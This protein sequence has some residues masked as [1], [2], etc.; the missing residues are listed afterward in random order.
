[1]IGRTATVVQACR[2]DGTVRV[3]G[4]IWEAHCSEGADPDETVRITSLDG[5]RLTVVGTEP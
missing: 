1:M 2:P 5:L 3:H 4:E